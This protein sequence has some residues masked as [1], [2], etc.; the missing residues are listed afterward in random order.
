MRPEPILV[1]G[2]TGYVGGRLIPQLLQAG[3]RVRAL[4]RSLKKLQCRPWVS[5]PNVELVQ[6]DVLDEASLRR[7]AQGC[8]AAFYLVHSML[9]A[10]ETYTETDRQ[11]AR[12][13]VAA[14]AQAG[15]NRIIYLGGLGQPDDPNLSEHLRSRTEVAR[16]LQSGPVPTTFLRAAMILG[17]GSASFEILRYLVDRLP[18]MTTP[19]WVRN[20]VQ[21][22]AISNVLNY[23]QGCLEHDEVLGQTFDIGGPEVVT[24]EQLF[25][26]YAEEAG[27]PRRLIIPVPVLTPR[28]SGLWIHLVTPVPAAIAQPLA[29]GLRNPVVCTENRIREI[30]PQRL[31][32][33]RET[34]RRALEKIRMQQV[35]T[36]WTDAGGPLPPEWVSCGD[37]LYAGGTVLAS[38][39]RLRLQSTPAEVWQQLVRIGGDTGYFFGDAWW[40]L[41][42]AVDRLL[43][44]S[45]CRSGRRHPSQLRVGD[46]VDFWRVLEVEPERRLLLLAEMKLPGEA[47]L[48]FRL[49]PAG[50]DQVEIQEISRFLPRGLGGILYW[51]AILPFHN[52]I[53]A[54]MLTG[55]AAKIGCPVLAGPERF[56]PKLPQTCPLPRR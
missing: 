30:I 22:I 40:R 23:L 33:C 20:P 55:L 21:P 6:G 24:Y 1:T 52:Y 48:E 16:I 19:K 41:R 2:A 17:S 53:F 18:V 27:L 38:G 44:G 9:A 5:H 32:T 7:A 11:A 47:I 34:I 31:L 10:P 26:I 51:Y 54:G 8:W 42:G 15:L 50:A 46:A 49:S 36:C 4:G 12:N 25:R 13:M 43:G 14:A 35:E 39:F 45:G 56:Q 3:Y 28:L 37:S 29:A